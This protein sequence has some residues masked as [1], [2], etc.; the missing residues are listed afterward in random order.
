MVFVARPDM[1]ISTL[2]LAAACFSA[3]STACDAQNEQTGPAQVAQAFVSTMKQ[4]H[5]D[6]E[7]AE[8]AFEMLWE[9]ARKNLRER[10]RRASALSGR[11]LHPGELLVPSWF[12]LHIDPVRVEERVDEPWANVVLFDDEGQSSTARLVLEEGEWRVALELPPLPPIR[13]RD[14]EESA[15]P[16]FSD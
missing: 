14:F 8:A 10:A 3:G 11:E 16:R 7:H 5:G 2:L 15:S 6:Q 12:A 1:E 13:K 4:V 9:P